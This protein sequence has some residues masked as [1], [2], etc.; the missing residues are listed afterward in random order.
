MKLKE[1]ADSTPDFKGLLGDASSDDRG[2]VV[3]KQS[4]TG[5]P[6]L[7][8]KAAFPK[9]QASNL[10]SKD[11]LAVL[12]SFRQQEAVQYYERVISTN[13]FAFEMD[14]KIP[15]PSDK[16]HVLPGVRRIASEHHMQVSNALMN[17]PSQLIFLYAQPV[18]IVVLLPQRDCRS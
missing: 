8:P 14:S 10:R 4:P 2:L 12:T 18:N 13:S 15:S 6:S 17:K 3:L 16:K 11:L 9:E 5:Q 1:F 7:C